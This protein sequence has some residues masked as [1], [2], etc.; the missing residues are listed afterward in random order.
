LQPNEVKV[1]SIYEPFPY[2]FPIYFNTF[3]RS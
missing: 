1:F 2:P 3:Y